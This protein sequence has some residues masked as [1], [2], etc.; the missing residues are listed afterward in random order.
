MIISPSIL[1]ADFANLGQ[2]IK[3]LDQAG[4]DWI[5]FDVMDG[6]FVPNISFGAPILQDIKALT[7][8]PFDVH[9]MVTE[10]YEYLEDFKNKGADFITVHVEAVEDPH[11]YF[12]KME[13]LGVKKGLSLSPDTPVSD[14]EPYLDQLDLVLVMSVHPGFGGQKFI[15]GSLDKIRELKELREERNLDFLIEVDGGVGPANAHLV[16][17]AGADALVA[18]SAILGSDDYKKTIEALR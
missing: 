10:P 2:E 9:L 7:D 4:A 17:E 12:R 13:E 18:G 15:E 11:K 8:L 3:D 16:K 1:A 14:L 5:H 6:Q